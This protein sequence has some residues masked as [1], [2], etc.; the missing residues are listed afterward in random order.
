MKTVKIKI[1]KRLQVYYAEFSDNKNIGYGAGTS[2]EEAI[3]DLIKQYP[4]KFNIV[5]SE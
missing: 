3:G 5:I 2:A 4:E 1:T